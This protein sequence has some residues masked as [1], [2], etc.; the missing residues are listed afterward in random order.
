MK[1]IILLLVSMVAGYIMTWYVGTK[2]GNE[3]AAAKSELEKWERAAKSKEPVAVEWGRTPAGWSTAHSAA[4]G[5][6]RLQN[7]WL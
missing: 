4:C 1:R 2:V 5:E 6:I 3:I 7:G